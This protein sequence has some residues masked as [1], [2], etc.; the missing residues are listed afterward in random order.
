[1]STFF[2]RHCHLIVFFTCVKKQEI[3]KC[4]AFFDGKRYHHGHGTFFSSNQ[5]FHKPYVKGGGFTFQHTHRQLLKQKIHTLPEIMDILSI[6]VK[7]TFNQPPSLEISLDGRELV[8]LDGGM[9]MGWCLGDVGPM[10]HCR[11]WRSGAAL[12]GFYALRLENMSPSSAQFGPWLL[13]VAGG[14]GWKIPEIT[15]KAQPVEG[16]KGS[17]FSRSWCLVTVRIQKIW[18]PNFM[19][20]WW[21]RVI[22]YVQFRKSMKN[23]TLAACQPL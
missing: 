20:W 13:L 8:F 14:G 21:K 23:C 10:T 22:L 19:S 1:M 6:F 15:G 7:I 11:T 16:V 17:F 3:E 18:P 4:R 12:I 5:R 2:C 9:M